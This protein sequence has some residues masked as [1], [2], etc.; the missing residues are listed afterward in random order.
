MPATLT[1]VPRPAFAFRDPLFRRLERLFDEEPWESLHRGESTLSPAW[2]PAVD[3]RE[4][5]EAYVFTAELPGLKKEDVSI[6]LEDRVLTLSGERKLEE[7]ESK[8]SYHRIERSYGA[9]SRSFTLPV[10]V[11][12]AKVEARFDSG[13]L[14]VKVP[15][16]EQV[17]P[18]RI[19]IK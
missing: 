9:F 2:A 5:G 4:T 19:D 14:T 17:K 6:T 3:V 16:A 1:R 7:E 12:S 18:R 10:E 11:D 15:K 13:L 8:N